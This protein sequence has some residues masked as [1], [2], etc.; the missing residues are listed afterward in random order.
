MI[1]TGRS[2]VTGPGTDGPAGT[3]IPPP[4]RPPPGMPGPAGLALGDGEGLVVGP[5]V[6]VGVAASAGRNSVEPVLPE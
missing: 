2:G 1:S 6:G 4:L 5:G 3:V